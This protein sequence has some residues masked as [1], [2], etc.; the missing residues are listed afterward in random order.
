MVPRFSDRRS[1]PLDRFFRGLA[2]HAFHG[3][4]GVVDPPLVDYVSTL[5]VRFIRNDHLR[6]LPGGKA[7]AGDQLVT[8]LATM[9]TR[10]PEPEMAE[11]PPPGRDGRA[12]TPPTWHGVAYRHLGDYT[13]FWTGLYPEALR[14]RGPASRAD[15]LD[16][17]RTAGKQAY[18]LA[19][20]CGT[21]N[22]GERSLLERLSRDYDTC[23]AGLAEVRRAWSES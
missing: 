6:P 5:L 3:R 14:R 2:E 7:E 13:L 15:R 16:E 21:A 4:L 8:M 12:A 10:P 22:D 17:Y 11:G 9:R 1:E 19:S 20:T 18:W 23:A